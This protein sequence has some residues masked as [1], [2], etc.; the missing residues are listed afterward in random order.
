MSENLP[1]K[2]GKNEDLVFKKSPGGFNYGF[3]VVMQIDDL[4]SI[5]N[6][7]G[8]GC[9]PIQLYHT[10]NEAGETFVGGSVVTTEAQTREKFAKAIIDITGIID[11]GLAH[12]LCNMAANEF[13]GTLMRE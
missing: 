3:D 8:S 2:S 12:K 1:K 10:K 11:I 13:Q 6:N 4:K 9:C 5:L 7:Y